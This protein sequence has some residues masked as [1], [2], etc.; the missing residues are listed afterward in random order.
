MFKKRN[1]KRLKGWTNEENVV[2][3]PRQ[4]PRMEEDSY[5]PEGSTKYSTV[6]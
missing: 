2:V 5:S 1:S 3:I 6:S 4:P